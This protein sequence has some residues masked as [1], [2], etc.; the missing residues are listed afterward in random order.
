MY[1]YIAVMMTID[2]SSEQSKPEEHRIPSKN[3][4]RKKSTWIQ[5]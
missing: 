5:Y 2:F 1:R 3:A 4:G